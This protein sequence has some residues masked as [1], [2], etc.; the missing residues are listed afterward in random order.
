MATSAVYDVIDALLAEA[1]SRMPAKVQVLDGAAVTEG[2]GDFLMIG[3]N[4]PDS[5]DDMDAASSRQEWA[6]ANHTARDEVGEVNLVA[7][8]WN[9]AGDQAQA[10]HRVKAICAGLE[11]LLRETPTLGLPTLLWTSFGPSLDFKQAQGEAGAAAQA[12]FTV[13]FQARI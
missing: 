5:E 2:P 12:T 13:L 6:H 1:P 9:G 10:R 4:D 3:S 7:L 11:D 8:S